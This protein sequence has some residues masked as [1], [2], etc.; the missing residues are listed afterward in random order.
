MTR[1]KGLFSAAPSAPLRTSSAAPLR[2]RRALEF[3]SSLLQ[4]SEPS[5]F[6]GAAPS[7]ALGTGSA[8]P[9]L[10]LL[11]FH[12]GVLAAEAF[13]APGGVQQLLLAGEEGMAG[14]TDFHVDVALV[15]GAGQKGVATG[16][17]HAHFVVS[18]MDGCLHVLLM[19]FLQNTHSTEGARIPATASTESRVAST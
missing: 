10:A 7:T 8:V 5:F 12:L 11:L 19:P 3:F 15:G 16:A 2:E 18:G 1:I 14:G 6:L 9:S 13:H 4:P 17:M